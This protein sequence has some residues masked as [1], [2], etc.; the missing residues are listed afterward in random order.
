[1][2][3]PYGEDVAS[4]IGP[5]SCVGIRKGAG[6]ALIGEN[7]GQVLSRER[8]H[9]GV[10]TRSLHSEGNTDHPATARD[11]S[12]PRGLRPC[13]RM[14]VLCTGTGRSH[15]R[16]DVAPRSAPSILREYYGD[17]WVWEVGQAHSTGEA[18]EQRQ[19]CAA[20]RGGSGG[21]GPDQGEFASVEQVPDTAP[22]NGDEHGQ[23]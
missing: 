5:E 12:T 14:E 18:S 10:P 22:G 9:F 7:A 3:V 6:E 1:M 23:P 13:A 21:K 20:A 11:G 15:T 4:H 8:K 16:P 2:E 17:V 19:R